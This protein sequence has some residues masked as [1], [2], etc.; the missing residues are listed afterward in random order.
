MAKRYEEK[1]LEQEKELA[2]FG[3][4]RKVRHTNLSLPVLSEDQEEEKSSG[5]EQ[6][7]QGIQR[8]D[9]QKDTKS[10][11]NSQQT[12]PNSAPRRNRNNSQLSSTSSI[13]PATLRLHQAFKMGDSGKTGKL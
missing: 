5:P 3:P 7:G 12:Q 9:A 8:T 2:T 4:S 10:Y 11:Q 6:T 13:Q 1:R